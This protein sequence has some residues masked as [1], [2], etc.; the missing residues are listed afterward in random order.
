MG[1]LH[2][3]ARSRVPESRTARGPARRRII[4]ASGL[5]ATAQSLWLSGQ[6]TRRRECQRELLFAS[7]TSNF[8]FGPG[9]NAAGQVAFSGRLTGPGVTTNNSAGVWSGL[10]GQLEIVARG[11]DQAPGTPAGTEFSS[12]G[13]PVINHS[14][15]VAFRAT[16]AGIGLTSKNSGGIWSDG[17]GELTLIA[18]DGS[19]APCV[20][21]RGL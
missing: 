3:S 20:A 10:P 9:F 7:F 5:N 14:G 17:D 4:R 11:G 13:P 2:F 12:F 19:Q 8:E 6:E 15:H 1:R 21:G 18:R 16:L